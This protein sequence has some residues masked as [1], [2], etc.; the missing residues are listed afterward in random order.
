MMKCAFIYKFHTDITILLHISELA[1][2]EMNPTLK[3]GVISCCAT[4]LKSLP[5]ENSPAQSSL[6]TVVQNVNVRLTQE[7]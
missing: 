1:C 2:P 5:K 4:D 7:R 3:P 6:I